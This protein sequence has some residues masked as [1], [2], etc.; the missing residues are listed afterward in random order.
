MLR[1]G[2][3]GHIHSDFRDNANRGKGLDT[4]H[5]HNKTQLGKILLGG[6]QNQ[7]FQICFAQFKVV[8]VG[9]DDAELFSLFFTHLSVHSGKHLFIG[10]FHTFGSEA[11][12]IRDFLCWVL[13]NSVCN[14][15]RCFPKHIREH[16]VQFEVG[17]RQ[18]VLCPVFLAGSEICEFPSITHQ[19][20][21]L[22]NIC[23]R[24]K[25]PSDKVVL[26]D[27]GNPLSVPLIRFLP[28]N[29][30]HILGVSKD[31]IAGGLQDVVNGNPIFPS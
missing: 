25:A 10:C 29:C 18:T 2:E 28:S 8:H 26:E 16:I 12:N 14:R 19:I 22:A 15:R 5:R 31:N 17:N 6:C 3:H 20:P 27:V 23:W 11:G 1:G 24:D 21:E 9:A 13:Q 4:R 30:F 7:R